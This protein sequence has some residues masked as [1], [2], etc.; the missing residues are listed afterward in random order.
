M[1]GTNLVTSIIDILVSGISG[2]ATGVGQG[3]STL[4]SG[5][6]FTTTG[7]GGDATTSLSVLGICIIAFAAISLGLSLC[8]WVLNFFTSL[9]SR[10][11]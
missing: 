11:R 8:R 9:G 4:A 10:N 7:S 6:F 2:I 5:I 3:L 1:T